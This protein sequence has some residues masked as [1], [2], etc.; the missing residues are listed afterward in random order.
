MKT[1]RPLRRPSHFLDARARR[2]EGGE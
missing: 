2:V 1:A